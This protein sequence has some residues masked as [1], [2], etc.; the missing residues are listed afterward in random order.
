MEHHDAP[1]VWIPLPCGTR[2]AARIWRPVTDAPVPAVLEFLPYRRRD[3]TAP[4]DEATYPALAAHGFAGVRVDLR[5]TGDSG[6]QFDD[7]YSETELSDAEATLA[8]IA[9]QPWCNGHVGMMGI[10]WGGFNALQLA[11]R[12]PPALKAVI[13][14]A[15]TV[16]R[17][18]DDIHTKGGAQMGTNLYWATQMLARAAVPPDAAVVGADWRK[19]WL[20]RL[21]AMEPL[22]LTWM[23]HQ[24][25]D[26]YWK[27]G[28]ICEDFGAV[29]A[30][31]LLIAGWAD[32]YRNTPWKGRA[33][34]G[35]RARAITGPWVH[36]YPHF[37][38]PGPRMD[39]VAEAAAWFGQHL[40]GEDAP[41]L[42][43]HRLYLSEAV[44]PDAPRDFEPGQWIEIDQRAASE[45]RLH[46]SPG[47]LGPAGR[48][49]T[50]L[51]CSALDTGVDGGAFFTQGG[52]TDLPAD[53][54]ADDGRSLCFE[55]EPSDTP[56][57][58][59]GMPVLRLPVAIDAPQGNLIARLV[60]V[61][62]DGCA[63][64]IS[65]GVLNL[66]HRNGSETPSPMTPGAPEHITLTLDATAYR[67]RPGHRLRL[68]L[69]TAYFPLILPPPSDV[70]ATLTLGPQATLHL[71]HA[72]HRPCTLP[73]PPPGDPRPDY[74]RQTPAEDYRRT[75]FDRATGRTDVVQSSTTGLRTH[76][77]H[78]L[79]FEDTHKARWSITR[80]DPLSLEAQE[81]TTALR[82]RDGIT[83]EVI[84]TGGMR[85]T[86]THWIV[87]AR[88]AARENDALIFERGWS[89]EI[90]RDHV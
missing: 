87:E 56:L 53:Q 34:L 17:F 57:D 28:S 39:F 78:G 4:R 21:G 55:T 59:I 72:P 54:R 67:L 41:D 80:G 25:R 75:H 6:G 62:P 74:P 60:D 27:H 48:T 82:I 42:P 11:A 50:T 30:P 65:M 24:R 40:R 47:T 85:A 61:H 58:I 51:L 66:A 79:G 14:I 29:E 70:T 10:S 5:G 26:G 22:A 37:A 69:S 33:G 1:L 8:W 7:E 63:H 86:A 64:R 45:A 20:D 12:R 3:V 90:P 43:A 83:T 2:L 18:A 19:I 76:P 84:A 44:R 52:D 77:G 88:L 9:A 46:L 73:E 68:A 38:V 89:E 35:A 49:Q 15:S 81:E 71:P 32:G 13:S 31:A 36:L 23:R 16:D